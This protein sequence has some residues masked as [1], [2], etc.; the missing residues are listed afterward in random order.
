MTTTGYP[1]RDNSRLVRALLYG[2]ATF[3]AWPWPCCGDTILDPKQALFPRDCRGNRIASGQRSGVAP[4][5][6]AFVPPYP[7]ADRERD[8]G[9]SLVSGNDSPARCPRDR[10]GRCPLRARERARRRRHARAV[11]LA[12]GR[13][14]ALRRLYAV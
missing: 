11:A 13:C 9:E 6:F 2:H 1:D 12:G 7:V 10:A 3:L 14:H 5:C 4:V 8:A